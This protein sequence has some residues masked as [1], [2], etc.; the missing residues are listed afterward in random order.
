MKKIGKIFIMAL[1]SMFIFGTIH[2]QDLSEATEVYN[3]AA[4][5]LSEDKDS[6]ALAGFQK[7]LT[8]AEAA[9]EEGTAMVADCKTIIPKILVKIG[10]A[11]ANAK[12]LDEAI[13]KLKEAIAKATEY[14]D[15][16][17]AKEA[18]ELIPVIIMA[19]GNA[20]LNDGKFAEAAAEYE[21]VIAEDPENGVA[22]LRLGMAKA[23][24][25][26]ETGAISAFE[27]AVALGEKANANKQ[28]L[29]TYMKKMVAAYKAKNNADAL[30]NA[31]KAAEYGENSNV[32]KI[33]GMA[34]VSLKKYDQGIELLTKATADASVNYNLAK[35]YEAKG[36][37]AKACSYYKLITADKNYGEYAKSKVTALCK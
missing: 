22:Y 18:K 31:L 8:L 28:L 24:L 30:A 33:G 34:A 13:A 20:L 14:G 36:N 26:D 12:N 37:N 17:T 19:D 2:A 4:T 6:E 5:A 10:K 7:A 25:N 15:T 35:A 9:G 11:A 23:K 29:N 16:E 3:N 32:Y 27:K 21:K 1:V